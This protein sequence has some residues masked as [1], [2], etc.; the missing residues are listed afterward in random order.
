MDKAGQVAEAALRRDELV[1]L[2]PKLPPLSDR[3]LAVAVVGGGGGGGSAGLSSGGGGGGRARVRRRLGNPFPKDPMALPRVRGK[4]FAGAAMGAL[5]AEW[6]IGDAFVARW[7]PDG[8]GSFAVYHRSE[9]ERALWASVPGVAFVTA[10]AGEALVEES[11]GSFAVHDRALV[12]LQHQAGPCSQPAWPRCHALVKPTWLADMGLVP[13]ACAVDSIALGWPDDASTGDALASGS[14]FGGQHGDDHAVP[15]VVPLGDH[16]EELHGEDD[17]L[18]YCSSVS[19]AEELLFPAETQA[20]VLHQD[21]GYGS[22]CGTS[23]APLSRA[24]SADLLM[25]GSSIASS[26]TEA[27]EVADGGAAVVPLILRGF[28]YTSTQLAREHIA[29]QQPRRPLPRTAWDALALEPDEHRERSPLQGPAERAGSSEMDVDCCLLAQWS[30]KLWQQQEHQLSFSVQVEELREVT[31]L[32]CDDRTRRSGAT[33]AGWANCSC[34]PAGLAASP[35]WLWS[36][37]PASAFTLG[38]PYQSLQVAHK[39]T[40]ANL[41]KLDAAQQLTGPPA[42]PRHLPVINRVQLTYLTSPAEGFFGFGEQFSH[43]DMKGRRI[44]VLV[45][46]QGLGRGDQPITAAANLFAHRSGGSWHTSY[47]P[48][49]YYMTSEMRAL[50][51][52]NYEYSLFDLRKLDEVQLQVHSTQMDGRILHGRSPLELIEQYTLSIGRMKRLPSW[53]LKGAIVGMQGGADKVRSVW[54][55]LHRLG[56]PLAAFWLQDWVGQRRTSIGWQL[57]WNWEVDRDHYRG[58][59]ALTSDLRSEDIRTMTYFNPLVAPSHDKANRRR[60]MFAE[61]QERGYFVTDRKG[62]PYMVPNTSFNAGLVDLTNPAARVWLKGA[63]LDMVRTGVSGWMADFGEALPFDCYLYSGEK[64]VTAHNRWPELWAELNREVV[65]EWEAEQQSRAKAP[66]QLA[67]G[68]RSEEESVG[69]RASSQK[70]E[71]PSKQVGVQAT[72]GNLESSEVEVDE[73]DDSLVFF[74]RSG[75]RKSPQS[76]TLFWEGDQ[77]VSWQRHDGIK[78]AV[79]G[80]LTGGLSGLAFNHSDIGGYCTVD[81]PI[82][83]YRRSEELLLRWMEVN[84]FTTV[85]RTHEGNSPTSNAQ[86]YSNQTTLS[87]FT[88]MALIYKSWYFYRLQLV[89]EAAR[90]GAPVVRHLFLHYPQDPEVRKIVYQEFLVGSELLVAPVLDAGKAEVDVYF[91]GDDEWEHVWTSKVYSNSMAGQRGY[92]RVAA[93]LGYPAVFCRKGSAVGATFLANLEEQG[94]LI[95]N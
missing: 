71:E 17:V 85:F 28:L 88:R 39:V 46:E 21:A 18:A 33:D 22:D 57:W 25:T 48:M 52:E 50:Y 55:Q 40:K 84:A 89:E 91:P 77:M 60:D 69:L 53:I 58:W 8:G 75:F 42:A 2:R 64:P 44:P 86:F 12:V 31:N 6:P 70:V 23:T 94:V 13:L 24:S 80:L 9:P 54:E 51:L 93:P 30:M 37:Q 56:A 27:E 82:F 38:L 95:Q 66:L 3:R 41:A 73:L 29:R 1:L 45:Q 59:E 11:R 35:A 19:S 49:P 4:L 10:A 15:A 43:F 16:T 47:A 87:A 78:S 81:T 36:H 90:T 74:V 76:A 61:G 7:R 83:S 26:S 65:D 32:D 14:W 62:L 63:M 67:A 68:Y 34:D 5:A 72:S 20:A 92:V 79:T